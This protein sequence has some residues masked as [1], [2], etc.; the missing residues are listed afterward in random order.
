MAAANFLLVFLPGGPLGEEFG[1]RGCARSS[2]QERFDWPVASLGL[3]MVWGVWHLPLFFIA[4]ASQA[5]HAG[6]NFWT[7]IIPLLPTDE[8]YRP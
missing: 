5:L 1:W 7:S 4:G 6:I 2:L 3:G 8:S